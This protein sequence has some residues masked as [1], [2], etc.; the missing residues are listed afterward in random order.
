[1]I[2]LQGLWHQ[3]LSSKGMLKLVAV[4]VGFGD[5]WYYS[6][7]HMLVLVAVGIAV[8]NVCWF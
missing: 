7:E 5:S 3:T 2:K 8:P 4:E 1:M 6:T